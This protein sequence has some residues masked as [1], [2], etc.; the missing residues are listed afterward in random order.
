[1]Y[2]RL[3]EN[4]VMTVKLYNVLP[5]A[6]HVKTSSL[7]VSLFCAFCCYIS[8]LSFINSFYSLHL[9]KKTRDMLQ[10]NV[11]THIQE[12]TLTSEQLVRIEKLKQCHIAQD[13]R[14][15]FENELKVNH[16]VKMQNDSVGGE[17]LEK[18]GE[19]SASA[20]TEQCFLT[21][22]ESE[23]GLG[24]GKETSKKTSDVNGLNIKTNRNMLSGHVT[25]QMVKQ[26]NGVHEEKRGEL[27][28]NAGNSGV[29]CSD[30]NIGGYEHPEG[31][32]LWDIFRRQDAPKLE[33][34]LKKYFKE[35]RHIYCFPV[36]QVITFCGV[37]F[38]QI[39]ES[40]V[41]LIEL[42]HYG[43]LKCS[44]ISNTLILLS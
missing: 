10:V 36:D 33:E 15:F 12:V 13:Q 20:L 16:V 6:Y 11:L 25:D 38:F 3:C 29:G 24:F 23:E 21:R 34:Y 43:F 40:A 41:L 17:L 37:P 4:L 8:V 39:E 1:M 27:D 9:I 2:I 19:S 35:F 42:V 18:H 30:N 5:P 31:G 22:L 28:G 14:E 44:A 7:K 32:A 26:Q